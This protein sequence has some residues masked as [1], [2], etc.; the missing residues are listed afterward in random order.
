MDLAYHYPPELY[1]LLVDTVPRLCRSKQ[2]VLTF[3]RGAGIADS[4]LAALRA[5]LAREPKN[6]SKFEITRTV[7]SHINE[8]GEAGL[9]ERREVLKRVVE[10]EDFSTCWPE[11]QLKAKGLIAEIRRVINVKD[12]F[13]R[14]NQERDREAQVRRDALLAKQRTADEQR[15][16]RDDAKRELFAAFAESNPQLRGNKLERALNHICQAHGISIREAF[17]LTD[18][19]S[20]TTLEQID[21]VIEVDGHL[22]LVEVKW[23]SGSVDVLDVSRHLVRVYHRAEMR[24]LFVSSTEFTGPALEVCREALQQTVVALCLV[25]EL[26]TWL[27]GDGD[28]TVLLRKKI[29]AA[30]TDKNPFHRVA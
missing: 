24:G 15:R 1:Q 29:V 26:V 8:R 13:A 25:S 4:A 11:D 21:G 14:M 3:F 9:R 5:R 17:R 22:Y 23:L 18:E 6:L 27:E 19:K 12:S 16:A 2:D 30:Q 10:F 28:L 7:L 20:G